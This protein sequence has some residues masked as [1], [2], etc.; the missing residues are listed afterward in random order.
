MASLLANKAENVQMSNRITYTDLIAALLV[1]L[2]QC[3]LLETISSSVS[4]LHITPLQ[5]AS[6]ETLMCTN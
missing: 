4:A 1:D 6:L 3:C 5:L 2:T